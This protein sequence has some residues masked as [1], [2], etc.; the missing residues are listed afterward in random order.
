[1]PIIIVGVEKERHTLI[2]PWSAA[3]AAPV[4]ATTL[5]TAGPVRQTLGSERHRYEFACPDEFGTDPMAF[6]SI[7]KMWT[8]PRKS[9]GIQHEIQSGRG[10]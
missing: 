6:G 10:E 5:R 7:K 4:T 3:K 9:G 1:M 8:P 2:G